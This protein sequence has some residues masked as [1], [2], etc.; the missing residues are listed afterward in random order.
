LWGAP[1]TS[2]C[3]LALKSRLTPVITGENRSGVGDL[4]AVLSPQQKQLQTS[5]AADE[6][7]F[8]LIFRKDCGGP[9][10]PLASRC[11]LAPKSR[12]TRVITGEN[13]SGVGDLLT[14]QFSILRSIQNLES[15]Q[16]F[17]ELKGYETL[18]SQM[19]VFSSK[20]SAT[21]RYCALANCSRSSGAR[22]WLTL[23]TR[24]AL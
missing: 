16:V 14:S 23:N 11:F 9:P 1:L 8:T 10:H 21:L 18:H 19:P 3:F 5:F 24:P 6:P 13:R 4:L 7:G 15:H 20:G 22:I 17:K 12:L 2:R